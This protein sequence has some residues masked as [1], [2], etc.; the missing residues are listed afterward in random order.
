MRHHEGVPPTPPRRD[1]VLEQYPGAVALPDFMLWTDWVL[2]RFG[3][4]PVNALALVA[5]CRDELMLPF[6][7]A[8]RATWGPAFDAASL[9]ALPFL[10]RTGIGAALGHTPGEDGRHRFVVFAFTH[11][12]IDV[13]GTVGVAHRPGIRRGTTACGALVALGLELAAA[14]PSGAAPS[15]APVSL[16]LDD[17]EMS[18]LRARV[19]HV[20]GGRPAPHLVGLTELVRAE[21]AADLQRLVSGLGTAGRPVDHVMISGVVVHGPDGTDLVAPA[22]VEVVVDGVRHAVPVS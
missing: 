4:R 19:A 15:D 14:A 1:P 17:V 22:A 16:D 9:A 7:R 5:V 12:G 18:L 13:D 2:E 20:L 10:G 3:F 8:V 6:R 21:A 11:I